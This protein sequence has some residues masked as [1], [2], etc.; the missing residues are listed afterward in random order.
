MIRRIIAITSLV[1][2]FAS[3]QGEGVS[4]KS[5]T[6]NSIPYREVCRNAAHDDAI[7]QNF[8]SIEAYF[9]AVECGQE[10]QFANYIRSHA[11]SKTLSLIP[12]FRE[13]DLYGNPVRNVIQGFGLFSGTTL[14]YVMFAD[15]ISRLFDLPKDYTVVEIGAGFGGQAYVL[16]QLLPFS[17]YYIYDLP[18]VEMLIDK[19][20][21]TLSVH[22]VTCLDAYVELPEDGID[23]FI[24]NYALTECDRPTQLDYFKRVVVKAKRGYML[25]NDTNVFD[26]LSLSDFIELFQAYGIHPKIHPEPVFSYT[27]N[28]LIT[29]DRTT[30]EK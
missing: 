22:N 29:W 14:R 24:S 4:Q 19:M 6:G 26:H 18:E 15:H 20:M 2:S 25:Y 17:Q 3:L 28:V 12:Q 5:T 7:F 13:L 30:Y 27:G 16:S 11:T 10:G 9:N 1:L 23:L 8:R 21:A